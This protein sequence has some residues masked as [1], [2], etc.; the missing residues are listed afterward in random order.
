MSLPRLIRWWL[1]S[2]SPDG[3]LIIDAKNKDVVYGFIDFPD[4]DNV[5]PWPMNVDEPVLFA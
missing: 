3:N 2:A 1:D 4:L 5:N